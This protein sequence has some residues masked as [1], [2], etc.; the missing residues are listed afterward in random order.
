MT[1]EQQLLEAGWKKWE[2]KNVRY[3]MPEEVKH[4]AI[5][6]RL[7]MD[8]RYVGKAWLQGREISGYEGYQ[9]KNRCWNT[10]CWY[11]PSAREFGASGEYEEELR[12]YCDEHYEVKP[13]SADPD[14]DEWLE[15]LRN[16]AAPEFLARLGL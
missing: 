11:N 7:Q 10:K 1:L 9:E 3:Y 5:G 13:I 14:D 4:A 2:A 12:V 15:D 16:V 8:G 6:L